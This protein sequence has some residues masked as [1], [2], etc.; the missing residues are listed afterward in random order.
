[1]AVFRHRQ[2]IPS[3]PPRG[4]HLWFIPI[5]Q[6]QPSHSETT[7]E[8][9][10]GPKGKALEHVETVSEDR[11][12]S[13]GVNKLFSLKVVQCIHLHWPASVI[14][15]SWQL[16][17]VKWHPVN[18]VLRLVAKTKD[19][20]DNPHC[21]WISGGLIERTNEPKLLKIGVVSVQS[22]RVE[23]G[24]IWKPSKQSTKMLHAHRMSGPRSS[25]SLLAKSNF[26]GFLWGT[27][28]ERVGTLYDSYTGRSSLWGALCTS[29]G[30][31]YKS[32]SVFSKHFASPV[33]S[34]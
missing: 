7:N 2:C 8:A 13:V 16:W 15:T 26:K 11:F 23:S 32:P 10:H 27:W 30:M 28:A 34:C 5:V 29:K 6:Q 21:S 14:F 25:P 22:Y 4:P 18:L 20:H 12:G 17:T 9:S 24:W 19:N 33:A 3:S 31:G 1:M